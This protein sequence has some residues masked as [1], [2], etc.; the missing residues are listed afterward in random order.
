MTTGT[1]SADLIETFIPLANLP[2]AT[3]VKIGAITPS[4]GV[5][6]TQLLDLQAAPPTSAT[7]I[8]TLSPVALLVLLT[9]VAGTGWLLRRYAREGGHT[10]FMLCM[11]AVAFTTLSAWAIVRDGNGADWVGIAPLGTD[12]SGDAVAG[13]DLVALFGVKDGANVS[14]R[15]DAVL[16]RD[17]GA[18][19]QPV[20]NA[21]PNQTITLPAG[22][23][24]SGSAT[25]DGL[26]NPPGQLTY[27]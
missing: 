5:I 9:L 3:L 18:N 13:D 26:P 15:V 7:P 8:P 10:L 20:V 23:T 11:V 24:L 16:A 22:A 1:G 25:D 27:L 19:Q 4:D 12:P 2:G 17:A 6:A 21:G 14:L